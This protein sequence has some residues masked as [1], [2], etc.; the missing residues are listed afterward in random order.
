[1]K[2]NKKSAQNIFKTIFQNF[3]KLIHGN[4][5]GVIRCNENEE[6]E[7]FPIKKK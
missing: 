4:I 5:E 7:I 1:M 2:F 3:F 6:I